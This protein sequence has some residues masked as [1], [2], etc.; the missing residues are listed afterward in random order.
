[1]LKKS[2]LEG[3]IELDLFVK[4]KCSQILTRINLIWFATMTNQDN[5]EISRANIFSKPF[6]VLSHLVIEIEVSNL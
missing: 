6:E 5:I 3:L 1:M 4:R 2:E